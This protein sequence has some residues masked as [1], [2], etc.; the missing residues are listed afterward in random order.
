MKKIEVKILNLESH[1]QDT[2]LQ[3]RDDENT[4]DTSADGCDTICST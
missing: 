4:D 1:C 2:F 3:K